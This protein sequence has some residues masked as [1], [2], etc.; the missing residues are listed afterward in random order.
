MSQQAAHD[1]QASA[2]K[3]RLSIAAENAAAGRRGLMSQQTPAAPAT[4]AR[5]D[6]GVQAAPV[7]WTR[8]FFADAQVQR[9]LGARTAAGSGASSA[10]PGGVGG[11][12]LYMHL[13][14]RLRPPHERFHT[15]AAPV[16]VVSGADAGPAVSASSASTTAEFDP[17]SFGA[18]VYG[19]ALA[20][21]DVPPRVQEDWNRLH[22]AS[23]ECHIG[24]DPPSAGGWPHASGERRTR[25]ALDLGGGPV[26]IAGVGHDDVRTARN[27][28][29]QYAK[30]SADARRDVVQLAEYASRLWPRGREDALALIELLGGLVTTIAQGLRGADAVA[31]KC[32]N[33]AVKFADEAWRIRAA[34]LVR[35]AEEAKDVE[36]AARMAEARA[37]FEKEKEALRDEIIKIQRHSEY[38][39]EDHRNELNELAKAKSIAERNLDNEK[40][41]LERLAGEKEEMRDRMQ[42]MRR[43]QS[44]FRKQISMLESKVDP[45]ERERIRALVLGSAPA[46]GD[47]PAEEPAG[48]A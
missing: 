31:Q 4:P 47:A 26:A 29:A 6:V 23:L 35:E 14:A 45:E 9:A 16:T 28:E 41:K 43:E 48:S 15:P 3:T 37:E 21:L 34:R 12:W 44:S 33:A 40:T 36:A 32:R 17:P 39:A 24:A 1:A 18:P 7:A 2:R 46:E 8:F 30:T 19:G 25:A 42:A 5:A 10:T 11:P 13:D 22:F 20:G 38:A 27:P